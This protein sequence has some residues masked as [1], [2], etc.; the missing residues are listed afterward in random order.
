MAARTPLIAVAS[1]VALAMVQ[2]CSGTSSTPAPSAT[3]SSNPASSSTTAP[4]RHGAFGECLRQ[5]GVTAPPPGPAPPP[6]VD[7]TTWDNAMQACGSLAPAP[8][9]PTR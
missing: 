4:T 7:Q 9:Q 5:H 8:P 3:T 1:L 6:G 2:A